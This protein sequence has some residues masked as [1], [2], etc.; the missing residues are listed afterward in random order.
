[1]DAEDLSDAAED[2]YRLHLDHAKEDN[3]EF[4]DEN[5]D[6]EEAKEEAQSKPEAKKPGIIEKA[7]KAY[8]FNPFSKL[9]IKKQKEHIK[10][11]IDA[12][13]KNFEAKDNKIISNAYQCLNSNQV[14]LLEEFAK[15]ALQANMEEQEKRKDKKRKEDLPEKK[16]QF[17]KIIGVT[18][19]TAAGLAFG[20]PM[21]GLLAFENSMNIADPHSNFHKVIWNSLKGKKADGS[22][23][24]DFDPH[25]DAVEKIVKSLKRQLYETQD[26]E[27]KDEIENIIDTL[28]KSLKENS[29]I[30]KPL[31]KRS[32]K[33]SKRKK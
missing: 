12:A 29:G 31:F 23:D 9:S 22:D 25:E 18:I 16:K 30:D 28:E 15:E 26:P 33:K 14:L 10:K 4:N 19:L 7:E 20:G 2:Y 11:T 24:P 21:L 17:L 27:H 5:E 3:V 1:M 13:S 32:A 6:F 8:K